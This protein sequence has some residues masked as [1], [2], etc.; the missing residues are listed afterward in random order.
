M[1]LFH[2]GDV[3]DLRAAAAIDL[4][5]LA[6]EVSE[7]ADESDRPEYAAGLEA[8]ERA[9]DALDAAA[10]PAAFV[11]VCRAISDGRYAM[12]RLRARL[13]HRSQPTIE[14]PC[15]FDPGHGSAVSLV[16]WTPPGL[17]PRT[18]PV[19]ADDAAIVQADEQPEPRIVVTG[20]AAVP[21]WE[22]PAHFAYWF[23]GHFGA[24][25]DC[26]PVRMLEGFP[27]AARFAEPGDDDGVITAEDLFEDPLRRRQTDDRDRW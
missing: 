5:Y 3:K 27:L 17:E 26:I 19:C 11:P 6:D 10:D 18:V 9:R 12:A 2:G 20:D 16:A 7:L 25:E 21:F 13:E 24:G 4:G 1:R 14:T 23:Q 15:F 8:Y 22:A